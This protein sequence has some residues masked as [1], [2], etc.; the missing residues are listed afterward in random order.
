[1]RKGRLKIMS[2]KAKKR[3][4][5]KM[6]AK[7]KEEN[8]ALKNKPKVYSNTEKTLSDSEVIVEKKPVVKPKQLEKQ[9]PV[10]EGSTFI[11]KVMNMPVSRR[12][13]WVVAIVAV[14]DLLGMAAFLVNESGNEAV[15][16]FS[17][18]Q[19]VSLIPF[20]VFVAFQFLSLVIVL[21]AAYYCISMFRV[22]K[23][24][25]FLYSLAIVVGI[26]LIG[27][28]VVIAKGMSGGHDL[29]YCLQ[30]MFNTK[31]IYGW[32]LSKPQ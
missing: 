6:K 27:D 4:A 29:S 30:Y 28:A 10:K 11:E 21:F 3:Y 20:M 7:R 13:F 24:K 22:R 9:T 15:T 8:K 2:Q 5:K 16:S 25:L 14:L 19:I 23:D 18:Y 1:M 12:T 31:F 17:F 32:F 26:I